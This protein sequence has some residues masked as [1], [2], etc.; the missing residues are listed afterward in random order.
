MEQPNV[1]D[2]LIL[3]C[4]RQNI[5]LNNS[6]VPE[7]TYIYQNSEENEKLKECH[8]QVLQKVSEQTQW[9]IE[10]IATILISTSLL[11]KLSLMTNIHNSEPIKKNKIEKVREHGEKF[12]WDLL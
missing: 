11:M 10:H 5:Y 6:F 8:W 1:T 4:W 12:F 3:G 2:K 9:A 7:S